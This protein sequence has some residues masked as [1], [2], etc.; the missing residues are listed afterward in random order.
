MSES[1]SSQRLSDVQEHLLALLPIP[2]S[3]LSI[4]GSS[5]IIY[6]ALDSRSRRKW[7]PYT[8][9]LIGLSISDIVSSI[10]VALASFLRPAGS[11][12]AAS[13]ANGNATTCSISGFMTTGELT[14]NYTVVIV[15]KLVHST[16]V[17]SRYM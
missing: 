5:I 14:T 8:R 6:I 12:R 7:S 3:I 16:D 1:E 9:L 10:N 17:L 15:H 13:F 4:L 11:P 2:A